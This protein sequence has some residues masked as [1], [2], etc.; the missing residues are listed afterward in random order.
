M[1]GLTER[2]G[3]VVLAAGASRRFGEADKLLA[4]L[5][6]RPLAA[7]AFA[8]AGALA[9][10]Q[11]MDPDSAVAVT[12]ATAVA[13]LAGHAGL[14]SVPVPPG[15]PQSVSV[16]TGLAALPQRVD[17]VLFLLA[18]MPWLRV[19]DVAALLRLR[20]PACAEAGGV[21]MPPALMPRGW[22]TSVPLTGDQGLRALLGRVA[23]DHCLPLPAARLADVDVPADMAD[24]A[25]PQQS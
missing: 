13:A 20:A 1:H 11:G 8:L 21:R 5:G 10:R 7:H 12:A 14:R 19:D 17:A 9:R 15:G 22:C 4:P 16:R 23:Q 6:G 18:D 25:T 24:P 3:I 2:L